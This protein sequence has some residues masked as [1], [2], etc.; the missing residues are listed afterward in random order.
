[1]AALTNTFLTFS[2]IGNREDLV[3]VIY[4]ISPTE[5]PFQASIGKTKAAATLHE[6]Q[7]DILATASATNAVVQ[8][9]DSTNSFT[10]TAP[11]FTVRPNNRTQISRKDVLVSGTQDA[12]SKA[13]RKKE[14]VYQLVKKSKELNRDMEAV[15]TQNGVIQAGGTLT[16]PT[17]CALENWYGRTASAVTT[18]TSVGVGGNNSTASGATT[19][20]D[21]T[22]RPLTESLLKGVLQGC[23]TNGGEVDL[24]MSGPFNKTVISGFTGNTTRIQDTTDKKLIAAIDIYVSDF[25]THRVTI[26]RFSRDRTLHCLMTDMFAVSYLRPRQTIDLAKTGDNE[27]AWIL[28]EYTLESRNDSGSGCVADLTTA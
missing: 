23:Y 7:T 9:D 1:M 3:D 11:V 4:N 19:R 15:L 21:G 8:G 24:L 20:V 17:L 10:F 18:N 2:A 25:G 26:D 22:Q 14:I 28:A 5:T 13:G 16:A 6:W 27:K 12:V